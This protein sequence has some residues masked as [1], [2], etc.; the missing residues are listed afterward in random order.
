MP[1]IM[2]DESKGHFI[3][4]GIFLLLL[5]VWLCSCGNGS[6][7][8]VNEPIAGDKKLIGVWTKP[9]S[10]KQLDIL[11][12]RIVK[13]VKYD[14]AQN[15]DII[16]IDSIVGRPVVVKAIDGVGNILKNK[17]GG[18]SINPNPQYILVGRDSVNWH[19]ENVS[20]DSLIKK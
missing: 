17:A 18:D 20:V 7:G 11:L 14:S 10:T 8:K 3:V 4:S 5:I 13:T 16:I 9:D 1:L 15:K 6:E 2:N 12:L 19:V